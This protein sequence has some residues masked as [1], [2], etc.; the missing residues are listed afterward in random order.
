ML[1]LVCTTY[2]SDMTV[3]L[4]QAPVKCR[5]SSVL[6][7]DRALYGA[8]NMLGGDISSC[9]NSDQ[10]SP[11]A[12]MLNFQRQVHTEQLQLIF[13]GGFVGQD[14]SLFV[15]TKEETIQWKELQHFDPVN[16][17]SLQIFPCKANHVT[18]LKILFRKSSDFYGRVIVYQMDV[19]GH[20][21]DE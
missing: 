9:W 11:Q 14:A 20:E 5:V 10:G 19:Q 3:S 16:D 1:K 4:V 6:N 15:K 7:K 13:Q 21:V 2:I 18:A 17:N 12:I 8:Q